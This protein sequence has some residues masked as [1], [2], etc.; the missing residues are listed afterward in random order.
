MLC[1]KE[2]NTFSATLRDILV[3]AVLRIRKVIILVENRTGID[4]VDL[5]ASALDNANTATSDITE[6]L[7]GGLA[8]PRSD[9]LT[10]GNKP[11][12]NL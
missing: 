11:D 4:I 10:G 6:P 5:S 7:L 9:S 3:L 8:I 1:V 2:N 12:E